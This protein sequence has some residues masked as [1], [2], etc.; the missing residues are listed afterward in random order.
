[1]TKFDPNRKTFGHVNFLL[2]AKFTKPFAYKQL[3]HFQLVYYGRKPEQRL[4]FY[5]FF[6][7]TEIYNLKVQ[8]KYNKIQQLSCPSLPRK[9]S[10]KRKVSRQ[11]KYQHKI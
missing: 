1:M 4:L 10:R 7:P 11:A 6:P 3:K 5:I 2:R 8:E 9:W